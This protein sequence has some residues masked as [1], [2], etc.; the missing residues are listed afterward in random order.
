MTL[1]SLS[2]FL[3]PIAVVLAAR[4]ASSCPAPSS[5]PG[6]ACKPLHRSGVLVRRRV[7]KVLFLVV[8][9]ALLVLLSGPVV[10]G[11][12]L[13]ATGASFALI[14]GVAGVIYALT[15]PLA[16]ITTIYVYYDALT[17]E[18]LAQFEPD[19]SELPAEIVAG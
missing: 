18:Q 5:R 17:R 19:S 2:V 10:G 9:S 7:L 8:G 4:W 1:L 6:R 3:I 11:L 15:M 16:G 13:I 12:L 14:N